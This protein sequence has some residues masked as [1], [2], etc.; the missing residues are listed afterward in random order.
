MRL[1][2]SVRSIASKEVTFTLHYITVHWVPEQLNIKAVTVACKLIDGCS[3]K[4]IRPH[5]Q[6][7]HLAYATE[8]KVNCMTLL[9]AQPKIVSILP[10]L[11]TLNILLT[12][13]SAQH[14]T[15]KP[16]D[17]KTMGLRS[18]LKI[19]LTPCR[20]NPGSAFSK[21]QDKLR[22]HSKTCPSLRF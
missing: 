11:S 17:F 19:F 15:P 5:L 3:L 2:S 9:R 1:H 18:R 20:N 22:Q 8:I 10:I 4:S 7:H 13:P 12:N 21:T 16:N 14:C 6:W